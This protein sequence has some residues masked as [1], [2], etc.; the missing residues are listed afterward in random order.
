MA[1]ATAD[2]WIEDFGKVSN[3]DPE[4]QAHG[5]YYSCS[6]LL[7]MGEHRYVVRVHRGKVEEIAA[8]P[9]PL[10]ER[11]QFAI[12]ASA[13]TWRKFA[14]PIPEPMYHG[15]WAASFQKDM[16]LEGDILTLMQNLRCVTRQLELLRETGVPV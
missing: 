4:L 6:F 12:R 13:D 14:Q 7:D 3:E 16:R 9:G 2:S 5:R 8:D 1:V 11:Y 10:D 15:I